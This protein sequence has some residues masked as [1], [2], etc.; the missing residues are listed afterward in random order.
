MVGIYARKASVD[1]SN[2]WIVLFLRLVEF[3]R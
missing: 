2:S 3:M 1:G